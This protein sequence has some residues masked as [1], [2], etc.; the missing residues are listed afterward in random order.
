MPTCRNGFQWLASLLVCDLAAV[1]LLNKQVCLTHVVPPY[2]DLAIRNSDVDALDSAHQVVHQALTVSAYNVDEGVRW[3]C[4]IVY[5]HLQASKSQL[6]A[7]I[8][9]DIVL[10]TAVTYKQADH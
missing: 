2:I 1:H 9:A 10:P 3:R 5:S 4:A 6:S 7:V 8:N